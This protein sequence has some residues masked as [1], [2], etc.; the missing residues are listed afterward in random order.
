MAGMRF[1]CLGVGDAFSARWYSSSLAVE[2]GG[3]RLLIDCPHP[4]RKILHEAGQASGTPLDAEGFDAL[5]L[6]HLHADHA[7]GLEGWGFYHHFV[8]K[9][10][11]VLFAHPE[12]ADAIWKEHLE[13]TMSSLGRLN[14]GSE[15]KFAMADYFDVRPLSEE[16]ATHFAPFT[17]ECRRTIHSVP[18]FAMKILRGR[19]LPRPE[20]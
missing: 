20:R 7:S 13:G 14:D 17:I 8:I 18:T 5:V 4:I 11:A 3:S 16:T 12:V 1:V 9:K 10:K 2:S 19:A 6:T 15:P